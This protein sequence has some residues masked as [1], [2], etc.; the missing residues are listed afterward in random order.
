MS[1]VPK[2]ILR[3]SQEIAKTLFEMAL[4]RYEHEFRVAMV[5]RAK[6]L[7]PD[8]EKDQI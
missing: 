2:D 5:T 3:H 6:G 8:P 7:Y 1:E 4:D